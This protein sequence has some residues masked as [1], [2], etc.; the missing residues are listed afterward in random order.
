MWPDLSYILHS[1]IG[2]EPDNFFSII[3]TFGFFLVLGFMSSAMLLYLE[4]KRKEADGSINGK[5]ESIIIYKPI[6][7]KDILFQSLI[8]FVFIFKI[9]YIAGHFSEFKEDPAAVLFSKKGNS[10]IGLIAFL[11]TTGWLYF[12]MNKQLDKNIKTQDVMIYP[13]QRIF[14][15]TM[16]AAI[17][18][19]IGSKLFSVLEN[20]PSF[21]KD[22]LGEIFS[23]SGLTIYGGLILAFI[24]V[25]RYVDKKGIRPIHM[26]DIAA[27]C[28][29]IGYCVGRMGC[30]FSGDGDWGIVNE[31]AKPDWFIFPDSWW[32][33]SYP[34]NVINEGIPI[35]A[36]TWRYC[37]EL[38]PKVFPTAF[39]EV[40]LAGIITLILWMLRKH[41]SRA[42]VLFFIYCTLNGIERFF[43]EFIRVNPRYSVLNFNL[44]QAQIIAFMLI[45]IGITGIIIC[46]KKN[47]RN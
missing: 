3:K 13:H 1:L 24:M 14:D 31:L 6:D 38:N 9:V 20:L 45:L 16:V 11:L 19:L 37:R 33:S 40:I 17:Y 35:E 10:L 7:W 15:I 43:I 28:M 26:M 25:Y 44:S 22:P 4:F 12:K 39:Y 46:W 36:C 47:I 41:I 5:L 23:G 18:G 27:P 42:G 30:H 32:A 21:L 2:T 29:M 8:N 34:H